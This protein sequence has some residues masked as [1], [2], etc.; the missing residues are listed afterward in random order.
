[1]TRVPAS[2]HPPSQYGLGIY[3][4]QNPWGAGRWFTHDGID[5]GYQADMIYAPDIDMTVVLAA[6]ASLGRADSVYEQLIMAVVEV[7]VDAARRN[8]R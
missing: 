8:H 1:M 3:V 7:A 2:D 5:P 6:N 4:Q